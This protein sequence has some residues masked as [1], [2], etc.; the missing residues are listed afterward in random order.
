VRDFVE[1]HYAHSFNLDRLAHACHIS[2]SSICHGL[3]RWLGVT[4]HEL[5]MLVRVRRAKELLAL[6]M[7]ASNVASRTG[8]AD[9]AQLTRHFKRLWGVT[10]GRYA[11]MVGAR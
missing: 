2:K 3:P 7:T 1:A 6:C 9:Q 5:Q 11:R 10:P 8:F 4:P